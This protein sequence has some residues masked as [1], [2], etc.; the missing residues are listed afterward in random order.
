MRVVQNPSPPAA[1][2][3]INIPYKKLVEQAFD[4]VYITDRRGNFIYTNPPALD[5]TG[6]SS[7]ELIGMHYS[8]LIPESW[9]EGVMKFYAEQYESR[10]AET[11]L[12]FPILRR[13]GSERWVEQ[14]VRLSCENGLVTGFQ[15]IVRDIDAHKKAEQDVQKGLTD[16][17][18]AAEDLQ[19]YAQAL[20]EQ[21]EAAKASE[22]YLA[23]LSEITRASISEENLPA[24]LRLLE[25]RLGEMLFAD[26]CW[27]VLSSGDPRLVDGER[28]DGDRFS[29]DDLD[30]QVSA[31]DMTSMTAGPRDGEVMDSGGQSRAVQG[32]I[33]RLALPLVAGDQK[34][35]VAL[36][37]FE[38]PR[39]VKHGEIR[40]GEQA[41]AQIALALA[42]ATLLDS[43]RRR[44]QEAETLRTVS[45]ALA[46]TLDLRQVLDI[47]LDQLAVVIDYDSAAVL[48]WEG[49]KVKAV[50]GRGFREASLDTDD[51]LPLSNPLL[52]EIRQTLKPI[53]LSN[54]HQDPRFAGWSHTTPI[55]SW[56]GMPLVVHG[57][58]LGFLTLDSYA[59]GTYSASQAALVQPFANQAA[60]AIE[61]ASL[62][63]WVQRQAVTDVLTNIYNRRGFFELG[64]REIER[65]LRF[66]RDL[67]AVML[68]IDRFKLVN[69][70][71]GHA[72]GDQ[73]L[74]EIARR[75]VEVLRR[76]DLIGRYGGEEFAILLPETDLNAAARIAERLRTEI[77]GT[78]IGTDRGPLS[79]TISL[80]VATI[81]STTNDLGSLLEA[82][83]SAMYAAKQAGRDCVRLY[84][85]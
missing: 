3:G 79:V 30:F 54:P 50:A 24:L 82:A 32:G 60:Q 71:L 39:V 77:S 4:V 34:L 23:I 11:T 5:L 26:A 78:R 29:A 40:W 6:Y 48:L 46:S 53:W 45:D 64:Q 56:M 28:G 20:D 21:A 2:D 72:I 80:G 69:D 59:E 41:A 9:R 36:I 14:T 16:L 31:A 68:D 44:R 55:R 37:S 43:E 13:D 76:V 81:H 62:F 67:A 74:A 7:E 70:R 51:P 42:K 83:D 27:I 25:A 75:C 18:Q 49:E 52:L 35:G 22:R 58:F 61:N 19:K 12:E 84:Q 66:H 10:M 17:Q 57:K 63:D 38:S 8:T 15:S 47:I 73:V 65:A 33:T 1:P 85:W